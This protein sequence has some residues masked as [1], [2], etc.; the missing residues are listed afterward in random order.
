MK[1]TPSFDYEEKKVLFIVETNLLN[2]YFAN[3]EGLVKKELHIVQ[4]DI[5]VTQRSSNVAVISF[6]VN[7]SGVSER[8][9]GESGKDVFIRID[10]N[11]AN[12]L[13]N[14]LNKF[15]KC[16]LKKE[17]STTEFIP[18]TGYPIENLKEEILTCIEGKR[19]LCIIKDY[20]EYLDMEK[21]GK[22]IFHQSIVEYGTDEY[23]DAVLFIRSGNFDKL[24]ELYESKL[25]LTDWLN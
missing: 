5:A 23:A 3:L 25:V 17:L 1:L 10:G 11:T 22:Y 6:S 19:K 16:A 21:T 20:Q 4:E 15:E 18:L 14:V 13:H 12:K 9:R 2:R 7:S 24:K 8:E